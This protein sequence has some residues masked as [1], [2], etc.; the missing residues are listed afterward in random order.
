LD[1]PAV[2]EWI[3]DSVEPAGE[4]ETVHEEP[5]ATVLR[6]PLV[7]DVAWFK[8]CAPVQAFEAD[9]TADL[10]SRW[11]DRVPEV[12]ACDEGRAWLLLA[13]AGTSVDAFGNPPEAW[14]EILPR[15]AELQR[16]EVS[17]VEEHLAHRVP[18]LRLARLPAGYDELLELDLPLESPE[19][20]RL[21]E[22]QPRF[23]QLCVELAA[24]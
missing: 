7:D 2:D 11:P 15:Y 12:I 18:D 22:F 23:A 4:I 21:R 13:D 24:A 5:W 10:F 3:R 9:L 16:G 14:L 6:V 19:I 1:L 20:D 17:H 8:A